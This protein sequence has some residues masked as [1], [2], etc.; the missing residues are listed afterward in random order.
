MEDQKDSPAGRLVEARGSLNKK[1]SPSTIQHVIH[2][3]SVFTAS[4]VAIARVNAEHQFWAK[5]TSAPEIQHN[6]QEAN[7][8]EFVV[9][10]P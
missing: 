3:K 4:E 8:S 10:D 7:N 6:S 1:K 5:Q 9:T 2:S